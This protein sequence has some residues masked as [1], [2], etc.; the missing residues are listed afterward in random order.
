MGTG[1]D[2]ARLVCPI[3]GLPLGSEA[4]GLCDGSEV[5]IDKSEVGRL[6]VKLATEVTTKVDVIDDSGL[7]GCERLPHGPSAQLSSPTATQQSIG[8]FNVTP[9]STKVIPT[10][11][12]I[13][14]SSSMQ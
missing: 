2:E 10:L 4:V 5:N 6:P 9:S 1:D 11:A 3:L 13:K 12:S 8:R 7:G 14:H